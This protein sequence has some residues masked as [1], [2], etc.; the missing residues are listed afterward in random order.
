MDPVP[1]LKIFARAVLP[2]RHGQFDVVSFVDAEGRTLED[3]ALVNGDVVGATRVPTRAH[4]ECVTGDALG[5]TRCDCGD[6]LE[7]ALERLST[8]PRGILLY[9]RQ[10]GRGIGLANK[11]RAYELQDQGMDTVE[12]NLHLGF[13]ADLRS[14]DLAASMLKALEVSSIEL[15][16]NNP[17]KV[18]GLR[19]AGIEV[20]RRV[21]LLAAVRDENRHYLETKQKRAG[22]LLDED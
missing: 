2:T 14:Y 6:Q 11:V 22:H 9:L 3:V 12:A 19:A 17:A 4:S 18:D 7:I 15:H 20:V 8:A 10:E 1:A 13:D 21:P 16:T 5:S